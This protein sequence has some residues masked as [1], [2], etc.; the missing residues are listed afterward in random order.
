MEHQSI[1]PM[2]EKTEL[3]VTVESITDPEDGQLLRL[4]NGYL[5]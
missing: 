3:P 1:A 5:L 4:E 2:A